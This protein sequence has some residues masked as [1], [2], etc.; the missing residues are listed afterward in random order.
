MM[1]GLYSEVIIM[2]M[3]LTEEQ[4]AIKLLDDSLTA[5]DQQFQAGN[6][7]SEEFVRAKAL[8]ISDCIGCEYEVAMMMATCL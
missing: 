8:I 6:L 4:V 7:S 3:E 2:V 1:R 5:L